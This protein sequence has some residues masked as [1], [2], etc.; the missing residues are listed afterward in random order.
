[1]AINNKEILGRFKEVSTTL[2]GLLKDKDQLINEAKS[3]LT[4]EQL[5]EFTAMEKLVNAKVKEGDLMSAMRI[6][7]KA[8]LN[9][10]SNNT[11]NK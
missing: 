11:E 2:K 7:S 10:F 8:R 4:P 9:S 5:K 1:M 6:V 3:N